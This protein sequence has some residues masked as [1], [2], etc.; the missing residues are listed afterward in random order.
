[1]NTKVPILAAI[2]EYNKYHAP[3][4]VAKLIEAGGGHAAIALSGPF[5]RTC[6]L[7]DYFDDLRL[8]LQKKVDEKVKIIE[9]GSSEEGYLLK[10]KW[11]R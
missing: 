3:E 4:A 11:S 2:E 10:L 6:G 5:C 9:V 1:M 8:E 7:Y